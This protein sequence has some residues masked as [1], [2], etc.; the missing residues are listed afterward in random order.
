MTTPSPRQ[1]A[2]STLQRRLRALAVRQLRLYRKTKD[3]M[4]YGVYEGVKLSILQVRFW[5]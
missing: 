5:Q 4:D 1:G 3:M 2:M